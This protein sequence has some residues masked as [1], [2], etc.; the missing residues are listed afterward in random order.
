MKHSLI[1]ARRPQL[2]ESKRRVQ[3]QLSGG[4]WKPGS[5]EGGVGL[6]V[7]HSDSGVLPWG[8]VLSTPRSLFFSGIYWRVGG[9]SCDGIT[10]CRETHLFWAKSSLTEFQI[11]KINFSNTSAQSWWMEVWLLELVYIV[12]LGLF[13][14]LAMKSFILSLVHSFAKY[15]LYIYHM[16]PLK[17]QG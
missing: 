5:K 7:V 3:S 2:C 6:R 10:R 15:L 9:W 8:G 12:P 4:G 13:I 1:N 17:M 11:T 16:P 14:C